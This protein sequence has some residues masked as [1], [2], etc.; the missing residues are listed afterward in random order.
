MGFCSNFLKG[1][2][3]LGSGV[4]LNYRGSAQFGTMLGGCVSLITG[5]FFGVFIICQVF[6]WIFDPNYNQQISVSYLERFADAYDIP[7]TSFL[8]TVAICDNFKKP[9]V[10]REEYTYNDPTLWEIKFY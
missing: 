4:A 8:P 7:I 6:T 10:T 9:N 2:D 5:I 3:A 1:H